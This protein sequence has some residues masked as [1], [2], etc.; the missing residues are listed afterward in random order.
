VINQIIVTEPIRALPRPVDVRPRPRTDQIERTATIAKVTD[1][2][3]QEPVQIIARDGWGKTSVIAQIAHDGRVERYTDG[4]A[5][6][7]GWGLPVEDVEQGIFD[8]FYE[9]TLPDT[10]HK[11]TPGQL[12]TH[13][14][15]I[16]AAILVDDLD[17]PRQHVDRL[18]DACVSSAFVSTSS[19]QTMWSG[20]TVVELDGMDD[21]DALALFQQR[22]DRV[23]NGAE[24]T[25]VMKF[26]T[27]TRGYPMAIV[28]AASA[29]RR[30][31]SL[32]D[33][34]PRIASAPDPIAAVHEEIAATFT[35][36]ESRLLSVLAAVQGDPLPPEAVGQAA[37][38]DDADALLEG[39][40][41]DG[42]IQAASPRYRLPRSSAAL[43]DLPLDGPSTAQG[44]MQ[45]CAA[46]V[47]A[48]RI[49]SA[50]PAIA[51]AIRT[52]T[53]EHDYDTAIALGRSA[54]GP[55]SLSGHWGVWGQI[56]EATRDA[57]TAAGDQ[58]MEGWSLHQLG[59]RAL[60]QQRKDDALAM[61]TKAADIRRQIGDQAGLDVTEHNLSLLA[62]PPVA[63]PPQPPRP[64]PPP[65]RGGIP[66]WAWTMI[67]VG[68]LAVAGLVGFIVVS[69]GSDPTVVTTIAAQNGELV[70]TTDAI[71]IF[72]VPPGES[73]SSEVELINIGPGPVTVDDVAVAG[74]GS[75]TV[76][77]SCG[78]L[79]P[80]ESCLITVTFDPEEPGEFTA[81]LVVRHSGINSDV[82]IPI[83]G[84]AI[85]PPDAFVSVDPINLD[86]GVILLGQDESKSVEISNEGD[87]EIRVL[88]IGI[89]SEQFVRDNAPNDAQ[90]CESLAPGESC[91][92]DVRFIT[93]EPG[94]F[95]GFL[96]IDHT[97][98]NSPS[99]IRLS[100]VVPG[101]ANL[102][103][104]IIEVSDANNTSAADPLSTAM[105]VATITNTGQ[106]ATTDGF[107]YRF[108]RMNPRLENSWIPALTSEGN[109]TE[110]TVTGPIGPGETVTVEHR[111]GFPTGDYA[112]GSA[113][114]IR[115]EV[116][117]CFA[118]EFINVPPCRVVES[119]EDDNVSNPVELL[120]FFERVE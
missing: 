47:D 38:V 82:A 72:D 24:L 45:W 61:L 117:S 55:L 27:H 93:T 40:K 56:L 109:Q 57:S 32:I 114:A 58:F 42:I 86:F 9:S 37:G 120:V 25:A 23:V 29:A 62:P 41:R 97:G 59:T 17:V 21:A 28:S 91:S 90:D 111:L 115:A 14:G 7:S 52:A 51:S 68:L 84:V 76:Q 77:N 12:R 65:T 87:L 64:T 78:S 15:N 46:E 99:E 81:S 39:L 30:G 16:E 54:D 13:L 85:E 5:V 103:I 36:A 60:A 116:D 33:L 92:V 20:G 26:L 79:E 71:E 43:L 50:G 31:A 107:E 22:L 113:T 96:V 89:D 70:P 83:L 98:E 80:S 74:H 6:I 18:I 94:V 67:A 4:I 10:V 53:R 119:F 110:F 48:S 104:E 106:T 3:S 44:L 35:L 8:A 75:I 1:A 34:L 88:N 69:Q 118:E 73:V 101:P 112:P 63:A 2:L 66:G 49:T 100:G 95:D 105:V 11:V 102:E 108:E 19:T